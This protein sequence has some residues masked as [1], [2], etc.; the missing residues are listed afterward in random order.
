MIQNLFVEYINSKISNSVKREAKILN[1]Y[2]IKE[3][4][5]VTNKYLKILSII[6]HQENMN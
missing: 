1:K 4:V 3:D 6:S 2:F 5:Y